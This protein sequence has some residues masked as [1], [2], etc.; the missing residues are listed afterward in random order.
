VTT[1]S[2]EARATLA[3]E[4]AAA[5]GREVSFVGSVDE[6]GHIVAVRAVARGT[7]Q[8]VL[9]LPGVAERGE[10]VLHNH[11][12]GELDPSTADLHVAA[13]LHDE[14][15][16]FAI[17]DNQAERLYVVVEVPRRTARV[18]LDAL[19]IANT[20][21]DGGSVARVLGQF[22]DRASQRDMAAYVADTYNEG[23]VS[24]LEAGTGVGKSF[25]YLVP[26]IEWSLAN[27][28]RTMVSTNT[29]NLQEQLIGKDLP[30][31]AHAFVDRARE[32]AFAI[33]KGWNNYLCLA[34]LGVAVSGQTS[35]LE[36]E[37]QGELGALEEWAAHTSDGSLADLLDQPTI[38]VWEEVR[39]EPDLCTRLE[40]PQF[41]RC[42]LF[43]AR[44]RA[45]EADVVVVNHHLLAADLAVRR[46][47]E[48]WQEAAVLPPY[49]RL[50]LDEGHHLEDVAAQHLGSQ[51]TSRGVLR[52]LSRLERN[53]KGLI[54]ALLTE[55]A[56]RGDLLSDASAELLRDSLLPA[57]STARTHVEQVFRLLAERLAQESSPV[58]RLD[59]QFAA[60]PLW[61]RGLTVAM[62][63]VVSALSALRDGVDMV[64]DR[65]ELTEEPDRRSQIVQE[66]RGVVR[67]LQMAADGF[68]L[69]LR[70]LPGAELVRWMERRGTRP[71]GGLPFPMALAAVPLDLA[72][73]LRESL[74]DKVETV[75]VTSA[76]L[77][78]G[79]S[80]DF[81]RERIGL[82]Q[83]P[84]PVR[85]AEILAS[86]FAFSQQC[87]LGVPTDLDDP[88]SNEAGH[89][90][91]VA[92]A[93]VELAHAS[94]GGLFV[95][96]TS[97]A[98]LR[99]VA[100]AVRGDVGARWPLLV[101]GEAPR[102]F[103]LRRFRELGSAVLL[104]TDSF[105]EGVDVPGRSLRAL[106]LAKLPF[107]VPTE[108]L[109]AARIEALEAQ[110]LDGFRHYLLPLAALKLKQGFGR[111]IRSKTDV[112]VV[113][114]LDPR[115]VTRNYGDLLLRSLPPAE[116]VVGTWTEVRSAAEEFFARHGIGAPA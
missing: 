47:Q 57:V 109:T 51:V 105:W 69:A 64:A 91:A 78:A 6:D 45:A 88:R 39:A 1:L 35:L 49:R 114:I 81:L 77:A 20:L 63:N 94:D 27:G 75:V 55:L 102:D 54:P 25:A 34:R 14:G 28:E 52:L 89:D 93:V 21:A 73:M 74:F 17:V 97:H 71:V 96:F 79:G 19:A 61:E 85:Y 12:S 50:I 10:M 13:G 58:L 40:C 9:A 68:V 44:R 15:V 72:T 26:A 53:G 84:D 65:M 99:R 11:P 95:L 18:P 29:I 86:P 33:L 30:V 42:F 46:A 113:M 108:P 37:L 4:I 48:N 98:A 41:D 116:R 23:G 101:Q 92:R 76:T 3:N 83:P 60:D 38:E 59:D 31:L 36:P 70:P 2:A 7:V 80:Y 22:E 67:R 56:V 16:G 8:E 66:L 104:G 106:V 5:G 115:V 112:G 43:E 111:L 90:R 107:K 87:L 82:A 62:D 110:G 103:L 32:P 100:A 24:L